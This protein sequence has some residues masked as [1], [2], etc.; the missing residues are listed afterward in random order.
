MCTDVFVALAASMQ[1][2][3]HPKEDSVERVLVSREEDAGRE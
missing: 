2:P 3:H 1:F